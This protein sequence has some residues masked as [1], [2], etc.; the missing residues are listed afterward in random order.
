MSLLVAR[1]LAVYGGT[2]ALLLWLAHRWIS[3]LRP[4]FAVALAALPLLF[5]GRAMLTGG[6]YAPLDI[7][8]AVAPFSAHREELGVGH[9][10]SPILG[11]VVY[12]EIPW[13]KVVREAVKHGRLPLWNPAVLAGEPLLAVQQPAVL[14]PGTWIGFLLP[15]GQA[16]TF[17]MAL[18][19]LL[20]LLC[21]YLFL[22]E[23]WCCE[24]ASL[25]GALGWAYSNYLVF[26][27]GYP[28]SPAAAPFPLLLLAVRRIVRSP[29]RRAAAILVVALLWIVAAGHPETLLHTVA[30]AGLYFLF[31][32]AFVDRSRRGRPILLALG[33]GALAFGL[34]AVLLLPLLEALPHTLEQAGRSDW[35]AHQKRSVALSASLERLASEI[36]PYGAAAAEKGHTMPGAF[37]PSGYAGSL[38]LPFAVAGLFSRRREGWFFL[39]LALLGV[40]VYAQTPAADALAKLPLFD[41]A[42]NERLIFMTAFSLCVLAALGANRLRDGEGVTAFVVGAIASLLGRA[43]LFHRLAPDGLSSARFWLQAGP[44]AAAT[45]LLLLL[46]RERRATTGVALLVALLAAQ[47]VLEAGGLYPTVARQ[48]FYP[49]LE[50]LAKIPRAAPYRMTSLHYTFVPNVAALYE[51]EDVRGYEAMTFRPLFE[52]YPLWC[53]HQPVWF[54]R[55]DD[56]TKPFLSFLNVRWVLQPLDAPPPAGWPVLAEADGMRLL[57]NPGV[58]PRA[59]VPR[60][61][62][63]ERDSA[64]RLELL[65]SIGDFGDRGVVE[66]ETHGWI[67]NGDGRVTIAS[68]RPD[69][70]TFEVDALRELL[71]GTSI[72]AWPGW[73]A[74]LDGRP[75]AS[76]GYNHAF[77]AF[78]VPAGRHRL[79]LSYAPDGFRWGLAIT[80]ATLALSV[81][82][83]VA[84]RRAS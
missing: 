18:R 58:L 17:E 71:V 65:K 73:K 45:A 59:F 81:A 4:R 48:A 12:Q 10:R 63:A 46:P 5:T 53:V 62:R 8:Y 34:S 7:V 15:L 44:L 80:L 2:A 27:L 52:T 43:W 49:P 32:L 50:V 36:I 64:R 20:A 14:H 57:E 33:S 47:R 42:L 19:I 26:Y 60:L 35:Y 84:S 24:T 30:G 11:D 3:P 68:Y 61:Y 69:A 51:L 78:R 21:G 67:A 23:I 1:S 54:N 29:N 74:S 66:G 75:A 76:L 41:I 13:R 37:E 16:W 6:V 25:L 39:G 40:A 28:L 77:L 9:P 70:M 31:E 82:W 83:S 72:T 55:V 22:R 38:L 79:R 56:P